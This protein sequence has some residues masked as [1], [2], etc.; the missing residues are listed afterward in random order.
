MISFKQLNLF[1]FAVIFTGA[2]MQDYIDLLL[3]QLLALIDFQNEN[4]SEAAIILG[5]LGLYCSSRVALFLPH[6]FQQW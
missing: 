3:P 4:E 6:F 1:F 5:R 2:E